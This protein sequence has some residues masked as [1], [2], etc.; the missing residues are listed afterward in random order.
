ML[1]LARKLGDKLVQLLDDVQQ[2]KETIDEDY[3][4]LLDYLS[5]IKDE[6]IAQTEQERITIIEKYFKEQ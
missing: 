1:I 5:N 3:Y 2:A 6:F 4:P